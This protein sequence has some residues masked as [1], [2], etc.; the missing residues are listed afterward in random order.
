MHLHFIKF[1][2]ALVMLA[3]SSTVFAAEL[4]VGDG[5]SYTN[6]QAAVDAASEGDVVLVKPN[7]DPKG[8]RENIIINTNNITLRGDADAAKANLYDQVC[9]VVYLDGCETLAASESCGASVVT[10]N[11]SGVSIEKIFLRHGYIIF[12][13]SANNSVLTGSCVAGYKAE[14]IRTS[15]PGPTGITISNNVF[16]GGNSKS[17]D[18]YGDN[19]VVKNNQLFAVDNGIMVSGDGGIIAN[20]SIYQSND[21]SIDYA[22][23]NGVIENNLILS[24]D[25]GIDYDGDNPTI[26]GNVVEG[27]ADNNMDVNCSSCT[28]GLISDNRIVGSVD[29]SEGICVSSGVAMT[30]ENNFVIFASEHGIEFSGQDSTIRNNTIMRSGSEGTS[31]SCLYISGSGNN[32]ISGNTI[33][34]CSY[35]GIKQSGGDNNTYVNNTIIGSGRTGIKVGNGSDTTIDSNTIK[36]CQGEGIANHA[37]DTVITENTVTGNRIDIC[38]DNSIATFTGNSN[39][40]GGTSTTCV[41]EQMD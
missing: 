39:A 1:C 3:I 40:T 10:V 37:T 35:I 31:E 33:K 30:I 2:R 6:I 4:V 7:S 16:Q 15:S 38:N 24:G 8:W 13:D 22:G 41:V 23:D 27:M 25:D 32:T 5:G 18:I 12:N 9:P 34:Y 11:G 28:G 19:H 14:I 29:D 36:N 21:C 26:R 17:I 20:N